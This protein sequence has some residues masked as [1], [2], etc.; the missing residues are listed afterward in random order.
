MPRK[1]ALALCALL[2]PAPA[3]AAPAPMLARIRQV[4]HA[5]GLPAAALAVPAPHQLALESRQ[6]LSR[7]EFV[8]RSSLVAYVVFQRLHAPFEAIA[9]TDRGALGAQSCRIRATDCRLYLQ[10]RISK[11][12]YERRLGYHHLAAAGRLL[13]PPLP[14]LHLP[15]VAPAPVP[16]P[17]APVPTVHVPA[18]Q[19]PA[20][21]APLAAPPLVAAPGL[22][23]MWGF[24][25]QLGMGTQAYDAYDLEYGQAILRRLD[26]RPGLQIMSP[27][28][29]VNL[30]SGLPLQGLAAS[31]DLLGT[32]RQDPNVTGFSFEGGLGVRLAMLAPAGGPNAFWPDMHLRLAL[33]WRMVTLGMQYPLLHANG[34][35]TAG[36]MASLGVSVPLGTP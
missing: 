35:P 16:T 22:R 13:P 15:P 4:A 9:F 36:W 34:D 20:I 23:P 31:C 33:R 10:D 2:L 17:P 6:P 18:A 21:A 30:R 8:K 3:L 25:Y 32:S 24:A 14:P 26:V 27:F 5:E 11:A 28:S 19:V 12:E 29:P 7:A 1:L